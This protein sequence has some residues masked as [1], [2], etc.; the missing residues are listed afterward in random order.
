MS[1]PY[2]FFTND[3]FE[4]QQLA[5]KLA[6]YLH[7]GDVITLEGD[8]GAG[9][10]SFTQGIAKGLEI[11]QVVNS[12][13]FTIIKEY[14]GRI[15]LYHMDVYRLEDGAEDL[16][17]EEYFYGEGVTMIE[18][19][20]MIHEFLP[21]ELLNIKIEKISNDQR[22]ITFEPKGER[23]IQLCEEFSRNE[24]FSD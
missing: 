17:F 7:P 21:E 22:K 13:T 23:Y 20:S 5:S 19:A 4:T 11:S 14:Y 6:K 15:P 18:W 2:V 24:D 12:P 9:K 16:G 1:K 10:T 3:V 8:L